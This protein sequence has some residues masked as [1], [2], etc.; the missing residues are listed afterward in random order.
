MIYCTINGYKYRVLFGPDYTTFVDVKD[1]DTW[2]SIENN[3]TMK[4]VTKNPFFRR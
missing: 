3:T 2:I 4:N 1:K